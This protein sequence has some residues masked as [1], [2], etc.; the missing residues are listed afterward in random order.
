MNGGSKPIEV[1]DF[2]LEDG[3]GRKFDQVP[4]APSSPGSFITNLDIDPRTH[5]HGALVFDVPKGRT[6]RLTISNKSGSDE[7][8]FIQLSPQ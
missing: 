3:A 6:Y 8:A 7:E 1:P 4:S 5:R 2:E